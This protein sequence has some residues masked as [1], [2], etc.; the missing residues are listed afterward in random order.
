MNG[1]IIQVFVG[2]RSKMYAIQAENDKVIKKVKGVSL[3]VQNTITFNDYV[4]CLRENE[5][6]SREQ[7]NIRSRLHVLHTKRETKLA[8]GPH[9]DKRYLLSH[10]T[11][12]L[13]WGHYKVQ[14]EEED[15]E[16]ARKK[17]KR[18]Q[19]GSDNLD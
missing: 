7:H 6:L 19:Q 15:G 17:R 3:T 16:P 11:D 9:D 12:T 10:S 13:P 8:L 14:E 2:L 4:R 1:R 5:S 18:S